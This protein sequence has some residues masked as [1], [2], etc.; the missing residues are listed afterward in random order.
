MKLWKTLPLMALILFGPG[1][2]AADVFKD[3]EKIRQRIDS[4]ENG[5]IDS[6]YQKVVVSSNAGLK[7]CESSFAGRFTKSLLKYGDTAALTVL[8]DDVP[9]VAYEYD[10]AAGKCTRINNTSVDAL[11]QKRLDMAA[12]ERHKIIIAYLDSTK[13]ESLKEVV[14]LASDTAALSGYVLISAAAAIPLNALAAKVD[15]VLSNALSSNDTNT[16][17]LRLPSEGNK[18]LVIKLSIDGAPFQ[19]LG[20]IRVVQTQSLLK[21][22]IPGDVIFERTISDKTVDDQLKVGRHGMSIRD[23]RGNLKVARQECDFLRETYAGI[24][25]NYDLNY[26]LESYLVGTHKGLLNSSFLDACFGTTQVDGLSVYSLKEEVIDSRIS[27]S[28]LRGTSFMK[29]FN[30]NSGNPPFDRNLKIDF[31]PI[32]FPF[33][34]ANEILTAQNQR[35][36]GCY[37]FSKI[38]S[39]QFYFTKAID[40]KV[41][42][43]KTSVD[44]AYTKEQEDQG[45]HSMIT[46]I[47]VADDITQLG[48]DGEYTMNSERCLKNYDF[49]SR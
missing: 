26:L 46:S 37:Q 34:T 47:V 33:R 16:T 35:E 2:V 48:D 39:R 15:V 44:Q 40:R 25:T 8:L 32:G 20:E 29:T 28:D 36:A 43:F 31:A 11:P 12:Q 17:F 6:G 23:Y 38:N 49:S 3:G 7:A 24:L 18:R 1:L 13:V 21:G 27:A 10:R 45:S 22:K 42:Y 30:P 14:S 19:D 5:T 41:Y 4:M 9:I